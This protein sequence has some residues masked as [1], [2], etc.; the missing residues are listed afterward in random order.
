M[1]RG[2][3]EGSIQRVEEQDEGTKG[4]EAEGEQTGEE[5]GT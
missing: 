5:E 4:V 2:I 1:S 3:T